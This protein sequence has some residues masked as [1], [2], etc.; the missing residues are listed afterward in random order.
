MQVAL[1]RS[2]NQFQYNAARTR[3]FLLKSYL[4]SFIPLEFQGFKSIILSIISDNLS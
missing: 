2:R 1:F 4:I 3:G